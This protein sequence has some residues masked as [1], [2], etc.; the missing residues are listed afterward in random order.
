M[1]LFFRFKKTVFRFLE[2]GGR[3]KIS[4]SFLLGIDKG[5]LGLYNYRVLNFSKGDI[6]KKILKMIGMYA[7]FF[8]AWAIIYLVMNWQV[9]GGVQGFAKTLLLGILPLGS[10]L[11]L[12]NDE[13][14]WELFYKVARFIGLLVLIIPALIYHFQI[15]AGSVEKVR[16]GYIAIFP[17][18]CATASIAY[19]SFGYETLG[20]VGK[21][22]LFICASVLSF[23]T[24]F[25]FVLI[26]VGVVGLAIFYLIL[27]IAALIV[28][29]VFRIKM[30]TAFY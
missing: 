14:D 22:S 24:W 1:I 28:L 5:Y 29:L 21:A 9:K 17:L 7:V 3:R 27:G 30:G 4:V 20:F 13:Y 12:A 23:L 25:L 26:G 11:F 18:V 19:I 10:A 2:K 16:S 8:V 6:M 15:I